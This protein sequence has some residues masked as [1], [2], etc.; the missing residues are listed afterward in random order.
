[1]D[2]LKL[3]DLT[4]SAASQSGLDL[5][6]DFISQF[7]SST[8]LIASRLTEELRTELIEKVHARYTSLREGVEDF[9]L[10]A[11]I[12]KVPGVN[13]LNSCLDQVVR[14]ICTRAVHSALENVDIETLRIEVLVRSVNGLISEISRF[15]DIFSPEASES[16]VSGALDKRLFL[17]SVECD[18]KKL[19]SGMKSSELLHALRNDLGRLDITKSL[20]RIEELERDSFDIY[21]D[22]VCA[23]LA[24][25]HTEVGAC[26]GFGRAVD[27]DIPVPTHM[28]S[29]LF[30][31]VFG[32]SI[33]ISELPN[34]AW[35]AAVESAKTALIRVYTARIRSERSPTLQTLFDA[36]CLL[37]LCS[38]IRESSDYAFF[39]SDVYK[40]LQEQVLS[41]KVNL[42]L[43]RELI[44]QSA[45]LAV[46]RSNEAILHV[47]IVNNPL[48][49]YYGTSELPVIEVSSVLDSLVGRGSETV[50]RFPV[51]PITKTVVAQSSKAVAASKAAAPKRQT[52]APIANSVTSFFNQVGKITLGS[53]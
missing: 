31:M 1:L 27:K 39:Q 22:S 3:F 12:S 16:L 25:T 53:K 11:K 37:V 6:S 9:R 20:S 40:N 24:G 51:L 8:G 10:H 43:Y 14:E 41:D 35:S 38:S 4:V 48:V 2:Q 7:G 47:F 44:M 19:A 46:G 23:D 52:S 49:L 18:G 45:F 13:I 26:I 34:V 36:A 30:G 42:I 15:A 5:S 33:K 28:T 29:G 21:F 50:E 17:N 32:V